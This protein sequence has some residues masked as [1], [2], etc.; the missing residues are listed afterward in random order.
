MQLHIPFDLVE[1]LVARFDVEIEPRIG[2]AQYHHKEIF[3]MH[4]AG[5]WF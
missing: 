3:V 2:P 5:D 4:D 1:E